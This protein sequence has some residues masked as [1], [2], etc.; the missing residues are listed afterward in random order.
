MARSDRKS[1][2]TDVT[3]NNTGLH[4]SAVGF[5]TNRDSNSAPLSYTSINGGVSWTVSADPIP[6]PSDE[7]LTNQTTTLFG[8]TCNSTGLQCSAVGGYKNKNNDTA[9]LSYT[10]TNGGVSWNV[11]SS[12]LTLPSDVAATPNQHSVLLPKEK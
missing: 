7:A 1:A 2:L 4:C 8:I 12:P 3:C 10:S 6:L 9:P 11:S 5:Y